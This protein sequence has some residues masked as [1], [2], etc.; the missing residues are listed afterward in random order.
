MHKDTV[1]AIEF[2][3]K[4]RDNNLFRIFIQS[5]QEDG[6]WGMC[7]FVKEEYKHL[8][9]HIESVGIQIGRFYGEGLQ[10]KKSNDYIVFS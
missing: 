7:I 8:I 3:L 2:V 1:R 5:K 10:V 6:F 9:P 4:Q